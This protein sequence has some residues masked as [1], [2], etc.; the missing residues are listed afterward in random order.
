MLG[1][2]ILPGLH[3]GHV[4]P[5]VDGTFEGRHVIVVPDQGIVLAPLVIDLG[6]GL[7]EA[8][9]LCGFLLLLH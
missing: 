9:D 8:D 3:L 7:L 4:D 5:C 1:H 2:I 6:L